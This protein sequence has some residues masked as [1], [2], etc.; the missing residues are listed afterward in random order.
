M[1]PWDRPLQPTYSV[2][3]D[4]YPSPRAA[5]GLLQVALALTGGPLAYHGEKPAVGVWPL[6]FSRGVLFHGESSTTDPSDIPS[7][8]LLRPDSRRNCPPQAR[9]RTFRSHP[10]VKRRSSR[11]GMPPSTGTP[12]GAESIPNFCQLGSTRITLHL[13]ALASRLD[14]LPR[15]KPKL[16]PLSAI[17][18][19]LPTC[20]A[21][22]DPRAHPRAP[23]LRHRIE[24]CRAVM[25][26]R[27]TPT[28]CQLPRGSKQPF[29]ARHPLGLPP[30]LPCHLPVLSEIGES[31]QR[32]VGQG[33]SSG[34]FAKSYAFRKNR[35]LSISPSQREV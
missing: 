11:S 19:C 10:R 31:P 26:R 4:A 7:P 18:R 16:L 15:T 5:S 13:K 35:E 17:R 1:G 24:R 32:W 14:C 33:S 28:G 8:S 29:G 34:A 30:A 22:H 6:L 21:H 12:G 20:A 2:F 25:P 23:I 3:K 9:S 27:T